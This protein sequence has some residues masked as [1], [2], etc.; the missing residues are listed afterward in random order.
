MIAPAQAAQ[1]LAPQVYLAGAGIGRQLAGLLHGMREQPPI[2]TDHLVV[3]PGTRTCAVY[4]Q[5]EMEMVAHQSVSTDIDREAAGEFLQTLSDPRLAVIEVVAGERIVTAQEGPAHD[6]A[7]AVIVRGGG[8]IDELVPRFG[9]GAAV[10]PRNQLGGA[11][12]WRTKGAMRMPLPMRQYRAVVTS[13]HRVDV[14][15][16]SPTTDVRA[17]ASRTARRRWM[18]REVLCPPCFR[19]RTRSRTRTLSH[20]PALPA[21]HGCLIVYGYVYRVAA[22]V[23]GL[24]PPNDGFTEYLRRN[25]CCAPVPLSCPS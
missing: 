6:A 9:H 17:P 25:A 15:T 14:L 3:A 21:L 22:Y 1:T 12:S 4:V 24:P 19:T 5:D 16:M 18:S 20:R 23:H 2:A 11:Q 10:R 13:P 8:D 7:D